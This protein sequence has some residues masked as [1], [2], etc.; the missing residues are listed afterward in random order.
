[1]A[2]SCTVSK[3]STLWNPSGSSQRINLFRWFRAHLFRKWRIKAADDFD[4][5]W[6]NNFYN[7]VAWVYY[8]TENSGT[9]W[10]IFRVIRL[11]QSQLRKEIIATFSSGSLASN[12]F[13]WSLEFWRKLK[14]FESAWLRLVQLN[15]CPGVGVPMTPWFWCQP[16]FVSQGRCHTL[17]HPQ[18]FGSLGDK[19]WMETDKNDNNNSISFQHQWLCI[20]ACNTWLVR[21][22]DT[23]DPIKTTWTTEIKLNGLHLYHRSMITT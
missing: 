3:R 23:Y 18:A 9:F 1:M 2:R 16:N 7:A 11:N 4:I 22:P 21:R 15:H 13:R 14:S 19:N 5:D 17:P 6:S 20:L 10:H 12:I 8:Q